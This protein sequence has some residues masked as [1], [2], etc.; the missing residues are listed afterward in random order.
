MNKFRIDF[1]TSLENLKFQKTFVASKLEMTMPTLNSKVLNPE[2]LTL[3]DL[4]KLL[5]LG[6][7]IDII[8]ILKEIKEKENASNKK[9]KVNKPLQEISTF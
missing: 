1:I 5:E 2:K 9:R 8:N 4:S 3:K 6:F 7:Q